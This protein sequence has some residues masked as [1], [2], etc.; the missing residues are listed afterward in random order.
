M[1]FAVSAPPKALFGNL[2]A[3]NLFISLPVYKS[4]FEIISCGVKLLAFNHTYYILNMFHNIQGGILSC[5]CKQQ[6]LG[7]SFTITKKA[8]ELGALCIVFP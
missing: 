6:Q 1:Y 2:K 8:L 5:Q 4:E 7:C 3:L